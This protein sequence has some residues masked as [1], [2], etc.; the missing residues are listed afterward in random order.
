MHARTRRRCCGG[1]G[2][3]QY[4]L[5]CFVVPLVPDS[6]TPRGLARTESASG[7]V[8]DRMLRCARRWEVAMWRRRGSSLRRGVPETRCSPSLR[9]AP[10]LVSMACCAICG[11]FS[12][13]GWGHFVV[14]STHRCAVE[15]LGAKAMCTLSVSKP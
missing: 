3:T 6:P 5:G 4:S 8:C 13:A 10:A 11:S 14:E 7:C 1:V 12:K 15:W 2:K 9:W